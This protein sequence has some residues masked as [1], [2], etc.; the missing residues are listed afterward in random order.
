M[1]TCSRCSEEKDMSEFHYNK[2]HGRHAAYCKSCDK[3]AKKDYYQRNKQVVK[4]RVAGWQ[5]NNQEKVKEYKRGW[6]KRNPD[7]AIVHKHTRRAAELSGGRYTAKEWRE[8]CDFYGNVCLACGTSDNITVDHVK[9]LSIGG[10][11]TI[12]NLQPLCGPC[13]YRKARKEI[14]YREIPRAT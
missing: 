1:R 12:D 2:N 7:V 6:K 13:N 9:P 14:D 8:L 3:I 10:T 4:E 5:Q 11:N